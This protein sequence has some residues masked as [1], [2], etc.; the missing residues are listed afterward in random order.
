[1]ILLMAM[2]L[3]VTAMHQGLEWLDEA[4][5]SAVTPVPEP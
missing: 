2:S 4:G 3:L 1:M 5:P